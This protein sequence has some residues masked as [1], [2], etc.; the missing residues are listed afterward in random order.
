MVKLKLT[1]LGQPMSKANSRQLVPRGR[2]MVPIK[3]K[4]AL[5]YE[6]DA[7]KQIPP[8]ARLSL[9]GRI[10]MR[11]VIYY[12]T[13]LPDLDESLI[14]DVLQDRTKLVTHDLSGKKERVLIQRGIYK[15]DRQVRERHV[16]HR[17]DKKNPRAEI[18]IV[19]LEPQQNEIRGSTA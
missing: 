9:T 13:E 17:I 14:L 19:A 2:R 16:Y 5:A 1:L 11:L 7:L 8:A 10:R 18:T 6:R 3:S 4:E 12:A 15:N